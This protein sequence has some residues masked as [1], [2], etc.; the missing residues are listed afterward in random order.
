MKL[1]SFDPGIGIM[2]YAVFEHGH[3]LDCG[4]ITTDKR[5]EYGARLNEIYADVGRLIFKTRPDQIAIEKLFANKG[6][7]RNMESVSAARGCIFMHAAVESIPVYEYAPNSV[8]LGV[9]GHGRA[10][11]GQVQSAVSEKLGIPIIKPDDACDAVA[12]GLFHLK[13]KG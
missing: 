1:L 7:A 8:K 12:I 11:K 13:Q 4:V 9:A 6:N 10:D 2:G 5:Q 3:L